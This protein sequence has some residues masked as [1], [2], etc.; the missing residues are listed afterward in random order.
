MKKI[1]NE[2]SKLK[3]QVITPNKPKALLTI[4]PPKS[5]ADV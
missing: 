3:A 1:I 4:P 5:L 2:E